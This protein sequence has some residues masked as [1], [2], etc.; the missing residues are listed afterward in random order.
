MSS[1]EKILSMLIG[2]LLGFLALQYVVN[3]RIL[4]PLHAKDAEINN[5][6]AQVAT[7]QQELVIARDA[8]FDIEQWKQKSLPP[9]PGLAQTLYQDYLRALLE[10]S[11]IAKPK[12]TPAA[13]NAQGENMRRLPFAVSA[14]CDLSQLSRFLYDFHT[15]H[16]FHQVRRLQLTPAIQDG[17]LIGFDVN[18][19]IEA[20]SLPD[21]L[22]KSELP[23]PKTNPAAKPPAPPGVYD[24]FVKKNLFQPTNLVDAQAKV[25]VVADTATNKDERADFYLTATLEENGIAKLWLTNRQTNTRMVVLQGEDLKIGGFAATVIQI[26]SQQVLLKIADKVGAVRLGRNLASWAEVLPPR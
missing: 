25:E 15:S 16:L 22:A 7:K 5:L 3:K 26:S 18:L 8:V 9:E 17:K 2:G 24:L 14:R 4:E 21:A 6:L 23:K 12:I 20:I 1:R 10:K 11:G 19:S 13:P